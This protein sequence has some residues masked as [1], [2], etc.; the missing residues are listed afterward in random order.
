MQRRRYNAS[1]QLTMSDRITLLREQLDIH[2][3]AAFSVLRQI[4]EEATKLQSTAGF[5]TTAP[6]N[7]LTQ[8]EIAAILAKREL[9]IQKR[10]RRLTK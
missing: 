6:S 7:G 2:L 9:T 3:N 8:S 1:N 4:R 10:A 5:S